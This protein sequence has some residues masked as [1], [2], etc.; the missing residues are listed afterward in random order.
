MPLHNQLTSLV[1]KF[2]RFQHGLQK[3]VAAM[4]TWARDGEVDLV[5]GEVGPLRTHLKEHMG[6]LT[7]ALNTA[8]EQSISDCS[9]HKT[10]KRKLA[11]YEA[12]F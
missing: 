9:A 2:D 5:M 7:A 6:A 11:D 12:D 3:S 10:L 4:T 1:S 8:R